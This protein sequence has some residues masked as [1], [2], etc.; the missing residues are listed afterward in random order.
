MT[1]NVH[2]KYYNNMMKNI[3]GNHFQ[4]DKIWQLIKKKN[5]QKPMYFYGY[6]TNRRDLTYR[7]SVWTLIYL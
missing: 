4:N 3:V 1:V 6:E 5:Y 2:T 7:R